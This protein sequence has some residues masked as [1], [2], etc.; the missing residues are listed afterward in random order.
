MTKLNYNAIS[1]NDLLNYVKQHSEDNEAFY[2]YIDS[3]RAAQP[4]PK[5]MS[6]EEAE[7]ELQRRVGQPL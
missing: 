5:P 4:D 2:T 6:V 1:D 7:A 3:K